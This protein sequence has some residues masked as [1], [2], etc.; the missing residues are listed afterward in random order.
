MLELPF[1]RL[2][3]E[4]RMLPDIGPSCFSTATDFLHKTGQVMKINE[5]CRLLLFIL[6]FTGLRFTWSGAIVILVIMYLCLLLS[7]MSRTTV[8]SSNGKMCSQALI[9]LI[10]FSMLIKLCQG[11][12]HQCLISGSIPNK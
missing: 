1:R 4:I 6:L 11:K 7:L 3:D 2:C 12:R 5:V 8:K 10:L 9:L